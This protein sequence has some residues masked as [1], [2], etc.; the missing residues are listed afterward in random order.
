[1][2]RLLLLMPLVL[3]IGGRA[4]ALVP[5]AGDEQPA[6]QI[7]EATRAFD[8]GNFDEASRLASACLAGKPS[9]EQ[10]IQAYALRAKLALAIDDIDGAQQAVTLLLGAMPDFAPGLDDPPRFVRMVAQLKREIARTSTSSVSKMNESLL[11]AP[12]TIVVVT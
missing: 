10:R 1:M 5:G 7:D 4:Y 12:A 2:K 11:E 3:A 9:T 8:A 6:C